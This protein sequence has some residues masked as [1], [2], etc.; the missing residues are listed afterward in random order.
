MNITEFIE[1]K[2]AFL[3]H[4]EVE[5]NLSGHTLRAY[6]SDLQQFID[7]WNE[8]SDLEKKEIPLRQAIERFL[9][10][11]YYRNMDTSSIARK[12]SCFRS[13]ERHLRAGGI[14]LSLKLQRPRLK[15]KL[16][17]FL[18]E[19]EIFHLLDT[20]KEEDL[21]SKKP[22]RDKAIFELLYATGVRCSEL[23]NIRFKDI[24]FDNKTIR[25]FGKGKKERMVLFGDK[26]REKLKL[27]LEK[28]RS[29][30][31]SADEQL[32]LNYRNEPLTP[33]SIQRIFEM[34]RKFLK[35]E[36]DI[37][38]HKIRHSFATHMLNQGADLRVVQELLGHQ[39]LSS[40]E[41]YTHVSLEDLTRMCNEIH[42]AKKLFE[43]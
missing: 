24:D 31:H 11:L 16:P 32:F 37:T 9:V 28:E 17:V 15:K 13:L 2:D 23:I 6:N 10:S 1:Q 29:A 12:F 35:V 19:D 18:S 40:T 26:A 36:R 25:I 30:I 20:V 22:I 4:L 27:Y 5:K 34:F 7:F 14:D 43:K 38:P 41:I 21:P 3:V 39:T 42:P 33:R 8:L